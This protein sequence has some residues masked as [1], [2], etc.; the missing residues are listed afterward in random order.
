MKRMITLSS[1]LCISWLL[2]SAHLPGGN[3]TYEC[4]GNNQFE[5]TL[6]LFRDCGGSPLLAQEL[7]FSSSCGTSFTLS[8]LPVGVGEEVS[9][10]CPADLPNSTCNGGT[11]PGIEVYRVQTTVTL[12]PC[13]SW[14]IG[15]DECCRSNSLNLSGDPGTYVEAWLNNVSSPCNDSPQFTQDVIPYVCVNEEVNYNLAVTETDGHELR[16]RLIAARQFMPPI[17]A[18]YADGNTGEEPYPGLAIDSLSGQITF[19]PDMIGNVIVVVRVDEYNGNGSHVGSVMR[20]F[21]FVV[22]DCPNSPPDPASGQITGLVGDTINVPDQQITLCPGG[23]FCF[24]ITITD[25]D[26]GQQL[27]LISNVGSVLPGASFV[28]SGSAPATATICWEQ[29]DLAA[30]THT[31]VV[32]AEDDAC[33][34]TGLTTF[35]YSITMLPDTNAACVSTAVIGIP[36][37]NRPRVWPSPASDGL[38]VD[39]SFNGP[40]EL[41]IFDPQGR[42]VLQKQIDSTT[43]MID[44]SHLSPGIH[45]VQLI[46][47]EGRSETRIAIAR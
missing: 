31:F 37:R 6:T 33:P 26:Q 22:I 20:D 7:H 29:A 11:L 27:T 1:S 15:W 47:T 36:D 30:G 34:N 3:I 19:T 40:V 43:S 25:P 23:G 2:Y 46:S 41:R 12:S 14:T 4:L 10:L 32:S 44:I 5:V 24:D 8:A 13:N 39:H 42:Q 17:A 9:Q 18:P 21:P 28:T 38:Y 45:L 16:Y 35:T